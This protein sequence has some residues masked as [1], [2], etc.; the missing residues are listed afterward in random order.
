MLGLRDAVFQCQ[1]HLEGKKVIWTG[2]I[3][4]QRKERRKNGSRLIRLAFR[5]R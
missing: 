5:R 4:S 3:N 2:P 1:L